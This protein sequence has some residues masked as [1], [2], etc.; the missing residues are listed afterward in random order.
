[1]EEGSILKSVK[2]VKE[3]CLSAADSGCW[4]FAV[5][6][7]GEQMSGRGYVKGCVLVAVVP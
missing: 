2:E 5:H 4:I 6:R 1:M 7:T 3:L